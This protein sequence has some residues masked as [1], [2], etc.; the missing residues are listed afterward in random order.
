MVRLVHR[1]VMRSGKYEIKTDTD[2]RTVL[3]I[4]LVN[5]KCEVSVSDYV[6]NQMGGN[7][8]T[9]EYSNRQYEIAVP[10]SAVK[11]YNES[12]SFDI[13]FIKSTCEQ[14]CKHRQKFVTWC[15]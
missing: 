4:K 13:I 12:L 1:E 2:R 10:V 9:A 6:K 15:D 11:Q 7:S 14:Y 5:G 8:I 3:D